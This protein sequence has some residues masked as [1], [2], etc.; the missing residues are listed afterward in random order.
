MYKYRN[1]RLNEGKMGKDQLKDISQ[2]NQDIIKKDIN[3][4]N[5]N[6]YESFRN[7]RNDF[8]RSFENDMGSN[9]NKNLNKNNNINADKNNLRNNNK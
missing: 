9:Q 8:K 2:Q 5:L 1:R 7:Q 4:P 3:Q 6:N